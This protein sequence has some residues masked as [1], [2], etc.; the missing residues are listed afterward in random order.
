M[1][2]YRFE[3][4]SPVLLPAGRFK[5]QVFGELGE[6]YLLQYS[7]DFESWNAAGTGANTTSLVEFIDPASAGQA[8]RFYRAR[9]Q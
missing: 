1:V 8:R 9:P 4:R 3:L 7:V 2:V 6:T 5:C